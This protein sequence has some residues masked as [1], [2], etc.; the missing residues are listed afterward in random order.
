MYIIL[1]E[2]AI[3][4]GVWVGLTERLSEPQ[5][6]SSANVS[7]FDETG[8]LLGVIF[9]TGPGFRFA[10]WEV[11]RSHRRRIARIEIEDVAENNRVVVID[12]VMWESRPVRRRPNQ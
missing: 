8:V 7:F 4:A 10:G 6:W 5:F 12:N 9:V 11:D 1:G 3:R 2:P